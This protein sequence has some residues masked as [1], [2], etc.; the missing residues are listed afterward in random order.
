M[1]AVVLL[2]GGLDSIVNF[3]CAF[4]EGE[5]Q[6]ALTCD[7]GQVAFEGE[8]RAASGC[9]ERYG[10]MHEIVDLGFFRGLIE[11]PIAGKGK[12]KPV[13]QADI[14][15]GR[16]SMVEDTW[17]PNRNAVLVAVGAAF[18]ESLGA[19][20]VVA[21]FNL[22]EAEL[23]PDN[24]AEFVRRTNAALEISTLSRV[25]V[26]TYTLDLNKTETV[27]LGIENGAPLEMVYSC[28]EAPREGMM[29]GVCQSCLRLKASFEANGV[30]ERYAGRFAA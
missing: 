14:E 13:S 7:Y 3:K 30:L 23:Y 1:K 11:N 6:R 22:E 19:D 25:V 8:V 15:A 4:D 17:V 12:L 26:K 20:A 16:R 2:S 5:V 18:A 9:A 27:A 21:G 29:C 24:S 10:V 28:Y